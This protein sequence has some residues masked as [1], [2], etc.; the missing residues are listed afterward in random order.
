MKIKKIIET[1]DALPD[2]NILTV[3]SEGEE[4]V[5]IRQGY[6]IIFISKSQ[7]TP[8]IKALQELERELE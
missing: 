1:I 5:Y 6:E 7:V 2:E 8:L 3:S 4:G